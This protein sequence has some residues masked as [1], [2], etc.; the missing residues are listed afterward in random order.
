MELKG[1]RAS[2]LSFSFSGDSHRFGIRNVPLDIFGIISVF[3]NFRVATVS[4][5][6][7]WKL[8]D[9]DGKSDHGTIKIIALSHQAST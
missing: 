7:S 1:H 9:T 5:D 3:K 2:V 4:K 8:W 6:G